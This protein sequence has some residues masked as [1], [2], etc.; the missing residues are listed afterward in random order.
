[1][2]EAE[3]RRL[4]KEDLGILFVFPCFCTSFVP[5]T[6][7][8]RR[9]LRGEIWRAADTSNYGSCARYLLEHDEENETR[10]NKAVNVG[11]LNFYVNQMVG[12]VVPLGG[13]AE[14]K[15]VEDEAV[16]ILDR[17][18]FRPPVTDLRRLS[19]HRTK[20]HNGASIAETSSCSIRA[21][22][23]VPIATRHSNLVQL[24]RLVRSEDALHILYKYEEFSLKGALACSFASLK[25]N[26]NLQ[27][28]SCEETAS[29]EQQRGAVTLI[30][31]THQPNNPSTHQPNNPSTGRFSRRSSVVGSECQ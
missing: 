31:S 24:H 7:R 13:G 29:E 14:G 22:P 4:A 17:L 9:I 5:A 11:D 27:E 10:V 18:Y 6:S 25:D 19:S 30:P 1:M 16:S 23:H 12:K 28:Y 20:A 3:I 26:N 21:G 2:R 8:Q 15:V